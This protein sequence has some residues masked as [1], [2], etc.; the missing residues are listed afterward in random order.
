MRSL[1]CGLCPAARVEAAASG[2][3]QGRGPD[4]PDSFHGGLRASG[5]PPRG[6]NSRTLHETADTYSVICGVKK[7]VRRR[8]S[9]SPSS[10]ALDDR[11]A[12]VGRGAEP[13]SAYL[14]EP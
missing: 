13:L 9:G 5:R 1:I 4:M 11:E 6:H 7:S 3:R 2:P 12:L 14:A 10:T 8:V